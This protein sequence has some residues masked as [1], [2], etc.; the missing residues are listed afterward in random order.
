MGLVL[1]LALAV[2][3][4]L[5]AL[6]FVYD[7]KREWF[8]VVRRITGALIVALVLSTILWASEVSTPN[9]CDLY[10]KYSFMWY[11]NGCFLWE[12]SS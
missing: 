7:V 10:E 12:H 8:E 11:A 9:Y 3:V 5:C 6:V 4:A 2:F 1:M